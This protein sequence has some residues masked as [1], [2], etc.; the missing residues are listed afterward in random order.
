M[1]QHLLEYFSKA[2]V[3]QT[4]CRSSK[5]ITHYSALVSYVLSRMI[6]SHSEFELISLVV[7]HR[8][9]CKFI[10]SKE[11]VLVGLGPGWHQLLAKASPHRVLDIYVYDR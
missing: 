6:Y 10:G 5:K 2:L 8:L 1:E 11:R 3:V 9:S 7:S 4:M